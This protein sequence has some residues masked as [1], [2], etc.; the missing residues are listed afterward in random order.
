MEAINSYVGDE[1]FWE[2]EL[3]ICKLK[4]QISDMKEQKLPL[5][6]PEGLVETC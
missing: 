1:K 2:L 5:D 4:I 6:I 3:R